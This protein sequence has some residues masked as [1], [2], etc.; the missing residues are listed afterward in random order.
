[1]NSAA[2]QILAATLRVGEKRVAAIDDHVSLFEERRELSDDGV[3]RRTGLDH[4]HR[5]ARASKSAHELFHRGRRLD[6]FPLGAFRRELFGDG[7]RPIENGDLKPF[8]LHVENEVLAHHRQADKANITLIRF[9]F[10]Y[11][12][13]VQRAWKY[14][15]ARRALK[16]MA[17]WHPE[18]LITTDPLQS[19]AN[20]FSGTAG[21]SVDFWG[22]VRVLED[23]REISGIEYEAHQPMAQHQMEMI[24]KTAQAEFGLGTNHSAPSHRLRR[25]WRGVAF[26]ARDQRTSGC[27]LSSKRMDRGRAEKKGADLETPC[28]R[29]TEERDPG[30]MNWANRLTLGRLAL[31]VFFVWSLSS[32]WAYGRTTA[33]RHLRPRRDQ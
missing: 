18:I 32:A 16:Q 10:R 11:L 23:G 3:N 22:A 2:F 33:A 13:K 15:S 8:R 28:F 9:H 17:T 1:M 19:P 5:F 27:R 26:P 25:S 12:L 24:A 21:A 30:G 20:N 7:C 14:A 29:R 31:T 4:D 6:V